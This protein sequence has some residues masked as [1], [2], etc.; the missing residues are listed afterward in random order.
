MKKNEGLKKPVEAEEDPT[1]L[2]ERHIDQ[3]YISNDEVRLEIHKRISTINNL[4][5]A[6]NLVIELEDRFG[7]VTDELKE[8]MYEKTV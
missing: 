3:S 4:N 1:I 7:R 8:Y 2:S 6:N 5:D